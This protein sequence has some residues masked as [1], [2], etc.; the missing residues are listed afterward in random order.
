MEPKTVILLNSFSF[1]C[2]MA[3]VVKKKAKNNSK[4]SQKPT[5]RSSKKSTPV[6]NSMPTGK[7]KAAPEE[8]EKDYADEEQGILPDETED[9]LETEMKT[10]AKDEDIYDKK[11]RDLLE[12]DDE[13]APWEE[14]F[15]EGAH[16]AGQLGK[17][18]LTGEPLMGADD[19]IEMDYEGKLYRFVSRKNAEEFVKRRK[20]KK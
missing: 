7:K 12:E 11:G 3:K 1:P 8:V 9:E 2:L 20:K 10:G 15:M 17:D 6:R 13:I 5:T 4:V 18:A 14:G 19:V 16:D